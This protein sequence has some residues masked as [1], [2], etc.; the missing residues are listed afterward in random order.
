[1]L[2]LIAILLSSA[3]VVDVWWTW[4]RKTKLQS[5]WL[6]MRLEDDETDLE[7]IQVQLN[8]KTVKEIKTKRR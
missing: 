8:G 3:L 2:S 7:N 4:R 6:E 1:M 5:E